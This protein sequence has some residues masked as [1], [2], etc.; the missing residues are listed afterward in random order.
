MNNKQSISFLSS[1]YK[2]AANTKADHLE[3]L[4]R[5][6]INILYNIAH[7]TNN[8]I[9]ACAQSEV[10][11]AK[12]EEE[13]MAWAGY[14]FCK[15]LC[16]IIDYL[17]NN[18]KSISLGALRESVLTIINLIAFNKDNYK[19]YKGKQILKTHKPIENQFPHVVELIFQLTTPQT[20]FE[21]KTRDEQFNK[22]KTGFAKI[23]SICLEMK[24]Q[25]DQLEV[26]VPEKFTHI[27]YDPK[28]DINQ[29]LPE[30]FTPQRAPLSF[31]DIVDF[32]RQYGSKYNIKSTDDWMRLFTENQSLKEK[33]TTVI[34]ALNRGQNPRD[35]IQIKQ[36]INQILEAFFKGRDNSTS[37]GEETE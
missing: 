6:Q 10:S 18:N 26:M 35:N 3:I 4:L 5:N 7:K 23:L 34:N 30:R 33:I 28:L 2:I 14:N 27:N 16:S 25:L 37:F 13:L 31:Y 29:E 36:E 22:A 20:R 17:Y 19:D 21:R 8:I 12:T 32:I 9:F 15:H 11:G 24:K 1:K